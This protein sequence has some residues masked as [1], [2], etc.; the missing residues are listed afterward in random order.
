MATPTL[1]SANCNIDRKKY[2]NWLFSGF[3]GVHEFDANFLFRAPND[4]APSMKLC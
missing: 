1:S 3:W 4:S 2:D